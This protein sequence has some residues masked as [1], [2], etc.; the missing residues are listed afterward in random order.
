MNLKCRDP[1]T[2]NVPGTCTL[3]TLTNW[4]LFFK[5]VKSGFEYHPATYLMGK[6]GFLL[7]DKESEA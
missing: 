3:W 4:V 6:G 7:E 1:N 2:V 5:T